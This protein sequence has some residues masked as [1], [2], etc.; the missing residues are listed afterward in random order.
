MKLHLASLRQGVN[1][2]EEMV[3]PETLDL[4]RE[5]FRAPIHVTGEADDEGHLVDIRLHL[6]T[7]GSYR[8]D[9][10][11]V[12]FDRSFEVD[13]RTVVLRR[14]ARDSEEEDAEGLIFIGARGREVDL[15]AEIVDA[16]LL[17]VPMRLLCHP[18]C[19]GLCP[20]CGA[21]LNEGP[22]EHVHAGAPDPGGEKATK[23]NDNG[24]V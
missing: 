12:E 19:R 3:L 22:C 8:C 14:E 15:G 7:L 23:N 5:V 9:R 10:C 1:P 24:K 13:L 4:D 2:V 20:V 6:S 18:E 21:D 11:A 16:L 17:D